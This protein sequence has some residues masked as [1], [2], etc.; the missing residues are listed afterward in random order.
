MRTVGRAPH[1]KYMAYVP[2]H[3]RR[4]QQALDRV[5]ENTTVG[6][7][8]CSSSAAPGMGTSTVAGSTV[9]ASPNLIYH[10]E[11]QPA[12]VVELRSLRSRSPEPEITPDDSVSVAGK[13]HHDVPSSSS[14][15]QPPVTLAVSQRVPLEA[16][17]EAQVGALLHAIGLGKYA[18]ACQRVPLRGR[19]LLHCSAED[20]EAAGIGFRPHRLSLLEEVAR[21]HRDGVPASMLA[22]APRHVDDGL[23]VA[24]STPTWLHQAQQILATEPTTA[25]SAAAA[26]AAAAAATE[27]PPRPSS[28]AQSDCD[29][30]V[31]KIQGL[32]LD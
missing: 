28:P 30:L 3:R 17:S 4:G 5:D 18:A 24:S 19:D 29:T 15:S 1:R 27:A 12:R 8:S 31:N 20:L 2:P 7:A 21:M 9:T 11:A 13:G 14:S 6:S 23:S 22:M 16:L 10:P 25:A 26:A 32:R